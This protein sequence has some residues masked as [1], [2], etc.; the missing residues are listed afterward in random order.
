ME[1]VNHIVEY[2]SKC[3]K[4]E[5]HEDG[6]EDTDEEGEI[7]PAANTLVEPLA[8]MVKYMNTLVAN[9]TVFGTGCTDINI[10]QMASRN[11]EFIFRMTQFSYK[12]ITCHFL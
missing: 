8:V 11:I 2:L 4:T 1:S 6:A 5:A 3:D 9:R 12:R 7:V 10:A